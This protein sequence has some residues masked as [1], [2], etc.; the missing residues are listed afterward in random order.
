VEIID[1][2][3]HRRLIERFGPRVTEWCEELPTQL[4]RLARKWSIQIDRSSSRGSH[5]CL[6]LC[7]LRSGEPAVLKL[8]P[9]RTLGVAEASALT[10]W[11]PSGRV[12]HL[13]EFDEEMGALLME[14]IQPGT[15][16]A[17]SEAAIPLEAIAGLVRDLH[18]APGE[19]DMTNFPPLIERVEFVFELWG[20]QLHKPEV[21]QHVSQDLLERSLATARELAASPG[22]RVLLH[23]DLH[24]HNVL[25]GG[26]DRGLVAV[27][28]R[29]CVG[30][31]ASD[32]IDWVLIDAGDEPRWRQ[33]AELLAS[34]VG[35]D[36]AALWR[37]CECMAVLM[38]IS[39]LARGSDSTADTGSLL[40]LAEST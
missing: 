31:P 36:P 1:D 14:A 7:R 29:A 35:V 13:L 32:L 3:T 28:P 27:D 15:P 21:A 16:L 26:P 34:E 8:S 24:A 10:A 33:R 4:D 19:N 2:A 20:K 30:D 23:G 39:R 37:W 12:P 6:L 38:V 22:P 17:D 9:D 40:S 18:S 11:R 25:D 5:S